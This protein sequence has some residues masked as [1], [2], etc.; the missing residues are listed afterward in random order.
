RLISAGMGSALGG[1]SIHM[2][3][4]DGTEAGALA[5]SSTWGAN[6]A[7]INS[8]TTGIPNASSLP[9]VMSEYNSDSNGSNITVRLVNALFFVDWLGQYIN[10]LGPRT[11]ANQFTVIGGGNQTGSPMYCSTCGN[12]GMFD[13]SPGPYQYLPYAS[14]YGIQMMS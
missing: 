13:N 6:A 7:A 14:Y 5:A 2:Y 9:V 8:G 10:Y 3:P 11:W 1:V 12:L 4:G